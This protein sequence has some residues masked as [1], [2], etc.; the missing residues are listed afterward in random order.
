M[1]VDRAQEISSSQSMINVSHNGRAIYIEHVDQSN[2]LATIH[3]L[4]DP[5][6]KE[7]VSV[8]DLAEH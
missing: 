2:K 1:D 8:S 7:S 3:H 4:N 5:T 6:I